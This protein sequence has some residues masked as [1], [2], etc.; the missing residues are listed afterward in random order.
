MNSG[1]CSPCKRYGNRLPSHNRE[2]TLQFALNCPFARLA[3]RAGELLSLIR[4]DELQSLAAWL[5]L[6]YVNHISA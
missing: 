3:L 2:S 4:D 5:I 6:S 1:I